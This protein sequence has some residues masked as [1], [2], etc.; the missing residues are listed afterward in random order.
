[1]AYYTN[2]F[3]LKAAFGDKEVSGLL[4]AS[5]DGTENSVRLARAAK[6]AQDEINGFLTTGGYSLPLAFTEFTA[7][8]PGTLNG[9]LQAISDCFTAYHLASTGDLQK[10]E[11]DKCREEG[12][13][14]LERLRLGEV[15]VDLTTV[16][17]GLGH[18]GIAV[19]SRPIVFNRH[20]LTER[21]VFGGTDE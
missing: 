1:M 16:E 4:R 19:I 7:E 13:A 17:G 14:W 2:E 6:I 9:I 21:Q 8:G 3:S 10:K 12:L 20:L 5:G 18:T 15:I 11:Y